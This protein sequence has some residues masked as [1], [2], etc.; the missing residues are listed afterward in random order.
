MGSVRSATHDDGLNANYYD[1]DVFGKPFGEI[2]DY[3]YVGKPYDPV[4]GLS[5]YGYRDYSPKTARFTTVDPIRD[6]HNWYA[7][8]SND[9]VN[10]VDLWGL[11]GSFLT[12]GK[13]LH[14]SDVAKLEPVS[15]AVYKAANE[16]YEAKQKYTTIAEEGIEFRCDQFAEKTINDAGYKSS[17]YLAGSAASKTVTDHINNAKENGVNKTNRN[18]GP[19]LTSGS[20]AVFM[21]DSKKGYDPHAALVIVRDGGSVIFWDNNRANSTKGVDVDYYDNITSFQAAYGYESFYYQKI[22]NK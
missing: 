18:E 8:C 2:S 12:E 5:N 21:G 20:Y 15:K 11:A 6:G 19:K 14:P 13:S 9:P 16:M 7:Y 22:K 1:Y 17:D 4:T 10:F 3:G